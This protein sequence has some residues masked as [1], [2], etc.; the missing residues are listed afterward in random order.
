MF[1]RG[2]P[3]SNDYIKIF[4]SPEPGSVFCYSPGIA[5]MPDGGLI[6]T[7][8][9]GGPGV[10]RMPGAAER[11]EKKG[12]YILG[13]AFISYDKGKSWV[14]RTDFPF[15]HARPFIAGKSVYI[16]G[17]MGDLTII[18]S[19][20]NGRTWTKPAR[21]T[22][23][24]IWHQ[25]PCN[26]HEANG[27]VYLVMEKLCRDD[28]EAWPVSAMAPILMRGRADHDLTKKKIGHLHQNWCI[29]KLSNR[30]KSSI[31]VYRFLVRVK[32]RKWRLHQEEGVHRWDGLRQM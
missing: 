20:D 5:A 27:Y 19:D 9:L 25:A 7:M 29:G 13:K 30:M 14:H 23:G 22:Q 28:V 3:L 4:E 31:L 21:L 8:D 15:Y 18:R 24:E 26:T 1:S 32:R 17:H 2:C 11:K 12:C 10:G 16:L 6:A